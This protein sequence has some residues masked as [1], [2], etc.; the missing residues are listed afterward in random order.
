MALGSLTVHL[1]LDAADYTDGLTKAEREAQ[2]FSD[3]VRASAAEAGKLLGAAAAAGAAGLVYLVKSS[4]DAADHLND[5]SKQTGIAVGTLGGIGFAAGQAGGN[6]ESVS[7]AAGKLNKSIAEAIAGNKDAV[8]A[9]DALGV[10]VKDAE[11][12]T[13]TADRVMIEIANRFQSFADGPEKAALALRLFGKSGADII[14]LLNDGGRALQENID[15]YQR[16]AGVTE[17]TARAADQFNDTL[18]KLSL[19]TGAFGRELAAELLPALQA[20]ADEILKV[21]ENGTGMSAVVGGIR[22]VFETIVV[23]GANVAF[24]FQGVGRE[25]GAIAAQLAALARMDFAG[26]RAISDAVKED[27][28]RARK[29]LDDF[30][31]RVMGVSGRDM[32]QSDPRELARRGRGGTPFGLSS[33]PSLPEPTKT[34]RTRKDTSADDVARYLDGLQRQI[35]RTREL[36][37]VEQVLADIQAKRIKGIDAAGAG[38]A[39]DLA[40]EIDAAKRRASQLDAEKQQIADLRA[41]ERGRAD[42]AR[43]VYEETRTPLERYNAEIERLNQLHREGAIDAG[44]YARAIAQTGDA[45]EKSQEPIKKTADEVSAF[46]KRARENIQDS[47]GDGLYQAMTGNFE[48]ITDAFVQMVQRMVAEALAADLT[49]RLFGDGTMP[50]GSSSSG[51]SSGGLSGLFSLLFGGGKATGGQVRAGGL[52]E[53]NERPGQSELLQDATG[54]Q[55]LI[56]GRDGRI[57]PSP[58]IAGAGGAR[59]YQINVNMPHGATREAGT[60]FGARIAQ[61]IS[62]ADARNN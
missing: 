47:I 58:R 11:G 32:G 54:R 39:L 30:E 26:F 33:A 38:R 7:A 36:S 41:A 22:T 25:I 43:R 61:Q 13:K 19:V 55:F 4:I 14:P 34:P 24:V 49:R 20:V 40:A 15:Y 8:Q 31:R 59:T 48:N 60:Q 44:T 50:S 45:F 57:D 6:L 18:G 1:G 28:A 52:Y 51:G 16:F 5:L 23:V 56:P 2:K 3:K 21:K 37:A 27:A 35:E 12:K 53:V 29:E 9:F 10:S 46:A 42:E 17:D 62:L